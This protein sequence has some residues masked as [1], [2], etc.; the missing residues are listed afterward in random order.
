V[1]PDH[2]PIMR[3]SIAVPYEALHTSCMRRISAGDRGRMRDTTQLAVCRDLPEA[4]LDRL[5]HGARR[6]DFAHRA[7]IFAQ[8]DPA[9]AV[10][11]IL[12]GTGEVRVGSTSRT[13]KAIMVETFRAGE[14]FGEMGVFDGAPRSADAM[15][16]GRVRVL[17][18]PAAN[19]LAV[20]HATPQFGANL[21][22]MLATR[23]RRTYRLLQ[24]ASFERLE[25]KLARQILYLLPRETHDA[26]GEIRVPGRLRQS[27]LAD[28]LGTTP[29]S[30][31]TVLNDWRADGL[32]RYDA[33]NARLT[34]I[35]AAR[36]RSLVA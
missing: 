10:Y 34:V 22:R 18:I 3:G 32:V 6:I 27:D 23:L 14:I 4:A 33:Q 31:I 15:A 35:D 7:L 1:V 25:V 2:V 17:R 19:F 13:G 8:N 9:D 28:L 16:D 20:L 21:A 24:D 30:I 12:A 11:G 26:G 36:L 5:E 29:R